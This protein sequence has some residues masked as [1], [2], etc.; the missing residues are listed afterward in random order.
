[1]WNLHGQFSARLFFDISFQ[2]KADLP[3]TALSINFGAILCPMFL[4][5]HVTTS[6][7]PRPNA[8]PGE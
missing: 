6:N 4:V 3:H 1:M 5:D 8:D 7:Q 2:S